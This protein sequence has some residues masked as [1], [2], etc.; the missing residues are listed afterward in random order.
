MGSV[1]RRKNNFPGLYKRGKIWHIDRQI[2]NTHVRKSL[3]TS[4]LKTAKR[5]YT[6]IVSEIENSE[7]FNKV[8]D[9]TFNQAIARYIE[10]NEGTKRSLKTDQSRF[11][12]ILEADPTL[13]KAFLKDIN[14]KRLSQFVS[15]RK[16]DGVSNSTINRGLALISSVLNQAAN[17][18]EPRWLK[19]NPKIEFLPQEKR[20]VR[21]P[22]T[23]RE[24][25]DL[26]EALPEYLADMVNVI[27][28]T[29]LRDG[30]ICKL[31]WDWI[32]TYPVINHP[33]ITLP[34]EITKNGQAR[35]IPLNSFAA[36]II[37]RRRDQND[38]HPVFVF[39]Q[40]GNP[41]KR[42]YNS[43]WMRAR[44]DEP[45]GNTVRKS[46]R[47]PQ[48]NLPGLRVHDLRQALHH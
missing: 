47:L 26:V 44:G 29:G 43:A 20:V 17:K 27:C 19:E 18:W 14:N 39:H 10:F 22:I 30:E 34:A 33:V 25:K 24:Q 16:K 21:R 38:A 31:K 36:Q 2:E 23:W 7:Y 11:R 4:D 28:C 6:Q 46:A 12:V 42:M 41:I 1:T 32:S 9:R 37:S 48:A 40:N 8:P 3:K 5:R 15:D 13:G 45:R 35:L